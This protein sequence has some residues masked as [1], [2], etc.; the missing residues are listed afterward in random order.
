[1]CSRSCA[2]SARSPSAWASLPSTPASTAAASSAM[3]LSN[4]QA[5]ASSASPSPTPPTIFVSTPHTQLPRAYPTRYPD[6]LRTPM[7]TT[8]PAGHGK[9]RFTIPY[10]ADRLR[11]HAAHD[12]LEGLADENP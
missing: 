9:L 12:A 3:A 7:R 1:P 6:P 2:S 8:D 11:E 4:P 10:T 5:T